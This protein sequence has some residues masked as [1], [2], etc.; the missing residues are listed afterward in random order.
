MDD[1]Y[2]VM[3]LYRPLYGIPV[4]QPS[5]DVDADHTVSE[6]ISRASVVKQGFVGGVDEVE[7]ASGCAE[8]D[9]VVRHFKAQP[10]EYAGL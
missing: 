2:A 3:G 7:E 4:E 8:Q 9:D 5:A 6:H 10:L 1:R